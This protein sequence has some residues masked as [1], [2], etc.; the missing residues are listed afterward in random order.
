MENTNN[1]AEVE[2]LG[3]QKA[4]IIACGGKQG[5]RLVL[6]LINLIKPEPEKQ[7]DPR[8][9]ASA[10]LAGGD[11]SFVEKA[12]KLLSEILS[13]SY[14]EIEGHMVKLDDNIFDIQF[15]RRYDAMLDLLVEIMRYNGFFDLIEY[16]MEL[17]KNNLLPDL[18]SP[19]T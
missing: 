5:R 3:G 13:L 8:N 6:R 1:I 12:D 7:V 2:L 16:L 14:I 10:L 4:R 18:L 17:V 19:K 15:S 11:D 9:V